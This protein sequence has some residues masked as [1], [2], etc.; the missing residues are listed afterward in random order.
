MNSIK[1]KITQH[2]A[3]ASGN[4]VLVAWSGPMSDSARRAIERYLGRKH[5][6]TITH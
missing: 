5:G 2:I 4:T 6:I 1:P 3:D